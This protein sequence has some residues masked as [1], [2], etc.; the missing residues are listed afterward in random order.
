MLL[1]DLFFLF[2]FF[3]WKKIHRFFFHTKKDWFISDLARIDFV[4]RRDLTWFDL[5]WLDLPCVSNMQWN[6]LCE[7]H[8]TLIREF[9]CTW[10][11]QKKT[12]YF[13]IIKKPLEIVSNRLQNDQCVDFYKDLFFYFS[14]KFTRSR[15]INNYAK[16]CVFT[17][18]N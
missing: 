9:K 12:Y 18:L 5:S 4:C 8:I 6:R 15:N 2:K 3:S 17:Y 16:N 13:K 7:L 14:E 10:E 11:Q 1:F